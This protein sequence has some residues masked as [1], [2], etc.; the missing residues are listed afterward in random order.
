MAGFGPNRKATAVHD[1]LLARA[2]VLQ[3]EQ[4][5]IALVSLDVVGFFHPNVLHVREQLAGFTYVLVGSTH[6]HEGP[7]TLGLW[8]PNPFTNGVDP[9]YLKFVEE[10][11]VK[12][13]RDA[14]AAARAVSTRLGTATAPELLHDAREPY[15]KHD[16][17][18]ALQFLDAK[19]NEAAGVIVQ[20]NCHPE[21][22]E[23]KNSQ[24]SADFVGYTV[25]YLRDKY[26]CPV[27][28]LTGT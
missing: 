5:K 27:V 11:C 3:H 4:K 6:N 26:R 15:V 14:D 23:S 28:Y 13:V 9:A 19:T 2:V 22:L 7:D 8:G 1:P 12:A 24:I 20:W 10:Q 16:E 25:G 17:L 18:T 21:T